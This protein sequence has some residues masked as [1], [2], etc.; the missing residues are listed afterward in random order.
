MKRFAKLLLLVGA[1]VALASSPAQAKKKGG[2]RAGAPKPACNLSYLPLVAG[3]SWTYVSGPDTVQVKVRAVAPGKDD[4]GAD[5]IV[6]KVVE[7]LNGTLEVQNEWT[8]TPD[9]GLRISPDSF[10]F[11]GEAGGRFGVDVTWTAHEDVWIH[12]DKNVVAESGWQEKLKG[13]V[14]RADSGGQGAKHEDAKLEVERYALVKAPEDIALP[15]YQGKAVK[16]EF[17][18]RGRAIIGTE[19]T[20]ITIDDKAPGE[21]WLVKGFGIVKIKDNLKG[22]KTWEITNTTV[23]VP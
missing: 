7:T 15:L 9:G 12:P 6:I 11:T 19:K 21:V 10:F 3:Y 18:L 13:D 8:C 5:V 1:A 20:E 17:Q 4:K 14:K 22:G 16:I 2:G 23:P